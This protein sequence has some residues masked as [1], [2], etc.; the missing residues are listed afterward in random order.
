MPAVGNKF[1]SIIAGAT[2]VVKK[3]KD[4]M[5]VQEVHN[6]KKNT[7]KIIRPNSVYRPLKEYF[8]DRRKYPRVHMDLPLE[9]RVKYNADARGAIIIDASEGGF[10]IYSIED[11][12]IGT[13]LEITALFSAEYELAKFEVLAKIIWKNVE[14]EKGEVEKGEVGYQYG[15]KFI[16]I[17]EEDYWKLRKLLGG[18]FK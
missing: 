7:R 12:P 10:L 14:V 13:K 15:L 18:R 17:L 3:I 9:Y 5:V 16:Q 11:I 4:K 2:Y 6:K 1:K 8:K